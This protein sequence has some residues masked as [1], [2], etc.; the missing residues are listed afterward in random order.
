VE[1]AGFVSDHRVEI[2]PA[3]SATGICA[4][5]SCLVIRSASTKVRMGGSREDGRHRAARDEVN[6][7]VTS[8][9]GLEDMYFRAIATVRIRETLRAAFHAKS[10]IK[11]GCPPAGS[12]RQPMD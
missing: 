6:K 2:D 5:S 4:G 12:N 3:R 8:G 1:F 10:E 9:S 11:T 7:Y